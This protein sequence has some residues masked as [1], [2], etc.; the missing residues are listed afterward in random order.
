MVSIILNTVLF[1][2]LIIEIIYTQPSQDT[3][4]IIYWRKFLS[5]WRIIQNFHFKKPNIDIRTLQKEIYKI[6]QLKDLTKLGI[7]RNI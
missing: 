6:G 2:M 1:A 7:N 4:V 3:K 5:L